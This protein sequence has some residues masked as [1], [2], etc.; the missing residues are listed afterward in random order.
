V[1]EVLGISQ[2]V[3]RKSV[4]LLTATYTVISLQGI[5]TIWDC[6][7]ILYVALDT[8]RPFVYS[9]RYTDFLF[10]WGAI[11][12]Q[13]VTESV[14]VAEVV[15]ALTHLALTL[16]AWS[17]CV[18]LLR[19]S[20]DT[21]RVL[22][23]L[24]VLVVPLPG[25]VYVCT[26]ANHVAVMMPTL[27]L[28]ATSSMNARR[29]VLYAAIAIFLFLD[30]PG[31][32]FAFGVAL[33]TL[34]AKRMVQRT[35]ESKFE[36]TAFLMT[37]MLLIATAGKSAIGLTTYEM[38]EMQPSTTILH[39]NLG[40]FGLTGLAM[41]LVYVAAI[42]CALIELLTM[43][44]RSYAWAWATLALLFGA[45][46]CLVLWAAEPSR[47]IHGDTYR[48]FVILLNIPLGVL[49]G[50]SRLLEHRW[51]RERR[52]APRCPERKAAGLMRA[53]IALVVVAHSS[54]LIIQGMNYGDLRS[55]LR[56]ELT[57]AKQGV[58]FLTREHWAFMTPLRSWALP[59]NSI[60]LQGERPRTIASFAEP[61]ETVVDSA[62]GVIHFGS[63]PDVSVASA[64][65][66]KFDALLDMPGRR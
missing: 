36:L 21:Q 1:R 37:T 30:H 46:A 54:C 58:T 10:G 32:I 42:V 41:L 2:L 45:S 57:H 49:L 59:F 4:V 13:R 7:N 63:I 12:A 31:S 5:G 33:A 28:L 15:F 53:A 48:K 47:W 18:C 38:A 27:V 64:G 17:L 9:Q 39:L 26:D 61:A 52:H 24:M 56:S 14:R 60:L 19:R 29:L 16:L 35:F 55:R 51:P 20:S 8:G 34:I 23:A 66:F 65:W 22:V 44:R 50:L 25:Q 40:L 6:S 62:T 11:A 43:P 3:Y